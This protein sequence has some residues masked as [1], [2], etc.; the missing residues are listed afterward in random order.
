LT[1][2]RFRGFST[3]SAL[4]GIAKPGSICL[5]EQA[6]WQVKGRFEVAVSDLGETQLKN[7]AEPIH[8][9]SF[10]LGQPAQA[11]R[12]TGMINARFVRRWPAIAAAL[13]LALCGAG[14]YAWHAGFAPRLMGQFVA[15]DKLATAPRCSIVVLP[16]EN[17]SGDPDQEYF[18]DGITDDL[19]TDLSHISDSFVIARN[20]AFTYKGRPVDAKAIGRE[21]GVRF[22]LEGSV[23]RTGETIEVNAQL[24]STETGAHVWA[25]RFESERR[26]LGKLQFEVVARIAHSLGRNSSRPKAFKQSATDRKTRMLSISRRAARPF[27]SQTILPSLLGTKRSICSNARSPSTRRI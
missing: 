1:R 18:V 10:E 23:R 3:K 27:W 11:T 20:T 7:I 5:S 26:D 9:Y 6:Y 24:V 2:G 22:L 25:D 14:A 19:T 4:E 16:F 12:R 15:A 8:V 13:A 17:L 21:L